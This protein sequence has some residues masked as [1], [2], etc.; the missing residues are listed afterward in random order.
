[1]KYVVDILQVQAEKIEKLIEKEKYNSLA[2][3]VATAIAN[4]IYL[5]E[6]ETIEL[7]NIPHSLSPKKDT[8]FNFNDLKVKDS[9]PAPVPLPEYNDI[10]SS[11]PRLK[12]DEIDNKYIWLW[13]QINRVLPIKIGLRVLNNLLSNK[14]WIN[15][16][17]F[18]EKAVEVA[19]SVGSIIKEHEKNNKKAKLKR[20]S[21]GLPLNESFKSQVRY[22]SHFLANM[23][24]DNLFDGAM[25]NLRFVNLNK[26]DKNEIFIG[27]TEPGIIFSQLM[28]PILDEED[29]DRSL[30]DGEV[31]FYLE[32]IK[33]YV[34]NEDY[35]FKWLLNKLNEG[36]S[37]RLSIN[38]SLKEEIGN[39]WKTEGWKATDKF[40]NTQ[41][42]GLM[43]RMF[44]LGLIIKEKK[45]IEVFYYISESGKIFLE[46]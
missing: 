46:K 6:S 42:A 22:K 43:A 17:D 19:Y 12:R 18:K 31:T 4:Q 45:G 2:Q 32:H 41:R 37:E 10:V 1:M 24:S 36:I 13:G 34:P 21:A 33:K 8:I 40:I 39:R 28:N 26:Q 30:N 20:I 35:A 27:L 38:K 16:N 7:E 15:L 9:K 3:F 29:F 11:V 14:Q 44:E 25:C 23:R 5:E